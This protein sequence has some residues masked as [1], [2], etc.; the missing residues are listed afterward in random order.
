LNAANVL[1]AEDNGPAK[2]WVSLVR[3]TLNNL[4]QGS[5]VYNYHT[6]SPAPVPIAELNVDFERSSRRQRNSSFFHRRSFQSF[7]RSSRIDM[8]DPHSLVDHR[9]SVCDRIS[10]GSRPSDVDT[11]MRCGGSSDDENIDEESP[12]SIFFSPMPCGYSAPLCTESR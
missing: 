8:M 12:S 10:F 5:G 6:P 7:N 1:L 9:F 11:S 4:D 2:K 3:K